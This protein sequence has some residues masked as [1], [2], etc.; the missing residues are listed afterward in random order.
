MADEQGES[1]EALEMET[2]ER[3]EEEEDEDEVEEDEAEELEE[4]GYGGELPS[5]ESD[6]GGESREAQSETLAAR[7]SPEV[8]EKDRCG[9]DGRAFGFL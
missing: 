1:S 6:A 2:L 7:C 4:G 9:G 8:A 3:N 5:P